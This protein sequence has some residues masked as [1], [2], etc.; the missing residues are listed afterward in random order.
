M[1]V[2]GEQFRVP[3]LVVVQ[4]VVENLKANEH[5]HNSSNKAGTLIIQI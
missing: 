5:L 1:A 4:N 2:L 3:L